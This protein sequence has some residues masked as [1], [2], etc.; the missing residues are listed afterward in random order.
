MKPLHLRRHYRLRKNSLFPSYRVPEGTG[1]NFA[2]NLS[3][4]WSQQNEGF[5]GKRRLGMTAFCFFFATCLA[6]I[7][8]GTRYGLGTPIS[9]LAYFKSPIGRLAFPGFKPYSACQVCVAIWTRSQSNPPD[10]TASPGVGP[11]L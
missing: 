4:F 9:R 2:R 7:S 10:W 1:I 11:A 8:H 3:G 6:R 5:L